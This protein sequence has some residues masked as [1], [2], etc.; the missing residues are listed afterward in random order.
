MLLQ[1][2]SQDLRTGEGV[3]FSGL[4]VTNFEKNHDKRE[5]RYLFFDKQNKGPRLLTFYIAKVI[6]TSKMAPRN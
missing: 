2:R 5:K 1:W 3:W 4:T 6:L